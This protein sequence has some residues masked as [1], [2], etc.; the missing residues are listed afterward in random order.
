MTSFPSKS[1]DANGGRILV[2]EDNVDAAETMQMLL[3]ISG[4]E[5]KTAYDGAT[6]LE[7]AK[8][9]RPQVVFLDIGLPGKNGYEVARELRTLPEMHSAL[10]VALTGYGHDDDR[11]RATEAGFDAFQV[12]PVAPGAL[13]TLLTDHF[14]RKS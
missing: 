8:A 7:L 12:K 4:Y 2:V 6:A 14:A 3:S 9:F 1:S 10:L 11:R 13:E 5:T